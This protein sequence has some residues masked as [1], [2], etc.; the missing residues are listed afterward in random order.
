M[1]PQPDHFEDGLWGLLVGDA[2]GVPYEFHPPGSLPE[3][4]DMF[5]PSDFARS[6]A[7]VP[8][9]TWSDDGAQ[10]L[11]LAA[12]FLACGELDLN[13]FAD[14]LLA[15]SSHGEMAVDGKVFDIGI[16]TGEALRRL[17][18]GIPPDQSGLSG[19]RNNGNG[20]L[21]RCLPLALLHK[22]SDAELAH[23]AARQSLVTHAHPRSMACCAF[24]VLWAR[25]E[26]RGSP[27]PWG[28]AV[29]SFRSVHSATDPLRSEFESV[30]LPAGCSTPSGSGYVVDALHSAR[31][32]CQG[33]AYREI[34]IRAIRLGH[35]TD[36]TA[37]IAGGIAG[38]RH[39]KSGIPRE[40]IE[41]LRSK[42]IIQNLVDS[43]HASESDPG[44]VS[45]SHEDTGA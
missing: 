20:S 31:H 19:E 14:R 35:D 44:F 1:S 8:M 9:G 40:W 15:W 34:V 25:A 30:I 42:H 23:D 29:A 18:H 41:G 21:M 4:I 17:A 37:C 5:P 10:A 6:Y 7:H 16:Q 43:H 27:D 3:T 26:M 36:T 12:S 32:A 24:Y 39:G 2:V 28:V 33:A 45:E 13:D 38:I 11:C 22:G